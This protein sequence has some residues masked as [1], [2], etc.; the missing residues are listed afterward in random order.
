MDRHK[1]TII[2]IF[3]C[4]YWTQQLYKCK[5]GVLP[6]NQLSP[7]LLILN[8]DKKVFCF[9]DFSSASLQ[10]AFTYY[11]IWPIFLSYSRYFLVKH[12]VYYCMFRFRSKFKGIYITCIVKIILSCK[13]YFWVKKI[14]YTSHYV[15]MRFHS[16]SSGV[17]NL[18]NENTSKF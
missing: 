13:I 14:A 16:S 11:A 8:S 2:I 15:S 1:C 4:S 3:A 12:P 6:R 7:S 18:L 5:H 17:N 9:A 10:N